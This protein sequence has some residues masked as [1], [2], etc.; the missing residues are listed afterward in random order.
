MSTFAAFRPRRLVAKVLA[1]V[2]VLAVLLGVTALLTVIATSVWPGEARLTAP[3]VCDDA[4]PDG[5][6]VVDSYGTADGSTAYD[7]SLFC[8]SAD[9]DAIDHGWA[10]SWLLLWAVHTFLVADALVL[11]LVLVRAKHR[12]RAQA[13]PPTP[14]ADDDDVEGPFSTWLPTDP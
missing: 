8:T 4:H 11:T 7:F 12:R 2:I 14:T 9:G 3:V 10:S 5:I 6:V 13:A 1:V